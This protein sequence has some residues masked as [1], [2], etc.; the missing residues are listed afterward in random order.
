MDFFN[1]FL[2]NSAG[3][4]PIKSIFG[5]VIHQGNKNYLTGISDQKKG[6]KWYSI[7]EKYQLVSEHHSEFEKKIPNK[8]KFQKDG[9]F[10]N[11]EL[12]LNDDLIR[13]KYLNT[14]GEFVFNDELLSIEDENEESISSI[15][16]K[17]DSGM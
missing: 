15:L 4:M 14:L 6:S 13:S 11:V 9:Q 3:K 17:S 2:P 16:E 8:D 5:F 1:T 12:V 7:P 10:R